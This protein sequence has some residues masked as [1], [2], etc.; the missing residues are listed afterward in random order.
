MF[1]RFQTTASILVAAAV[2]AA[3][4]L[5]R[6]ADQGYFANALVSDQ[7]G[8]APHTDAKLIDPR[9]ILARPDG[10]VIIANGGSDASTAYHPDGAPYALIIDVPPGAAASGPAIPT[11]LGYNTSSGFVISNGIASAPAHVMLVTKSGTIA[12]FNAQVD[13]KSAITAVDNSAKDAV[14]TGCAMGGNDNGLFLYAANFKSGF[15]EMYGPGFKLVK[16][17]T[18]AKI[19]KDYGPFGIRN[20]NRRLYVTYAKR[21]APDYTGA[22]PG[23]GQGY[24]DVFDLNGKLTKRLVARGNLNAPWGLAMAGD[25][26]GSY[27]GDLLVANHGNGHI[28]A[29]DPTTGQL[30]G[31]LSMPSGESLTIEGLFGIALAKVNIVP[32]QEDDILYYT[33]DPNDHHDGVLGIVTV[34]P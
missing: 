1:T 9:G 18:D 8:V 30:D 32:N 15:V 4:P 6:T 33:A 20:I 19:P 25:D 27:S 16:S 13:P 2:L 24:V 29:Y 14:Y 11:G 17:F 22:E 12:G 3:A 5:A 21:L 26:F 23:V 10:R 28:N 7:P 31:I 34:A